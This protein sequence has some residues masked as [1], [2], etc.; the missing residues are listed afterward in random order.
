MRQKSG[1]EKRP[2]EKQSCRE[3]AISQPDDGSPKISMF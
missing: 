1:P 3:F 2:V